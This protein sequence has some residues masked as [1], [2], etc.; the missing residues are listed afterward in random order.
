MQ[1]VDM[2]AHVGKDESG[3][4]GM[5][6]VCVL[7]RALA[8]RLAL[9]MARA[10]DTG[11]YVLRSQVRG[12]PL[13]R[14][15]KQQGPGCAMTPG[16]YVSML[17]MQRQLAP[18]AGAGPLGQALVKPRVQRSMVTSAQLLA[19]KDRSCTCDDCHASHV[20]SACRVLD[21]LGFG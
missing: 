8:P 4:C 21:L 16:S 15:R 18:W 20:V 10:R 6:Y 11:G 1:L 19:G 13:H 7:P 17:H 3:S 5:P 2:G 9:F 14:M 12:L